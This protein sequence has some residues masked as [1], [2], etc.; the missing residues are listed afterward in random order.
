MVARHEPFPR[1]ASGKIRVEMPRTPIEVVPTPV[2]EPSAEHVS[3]W[4]GFWRHRRRPAT[5]LV[6]A[7]VVTLA[8]VALLVLMVN[9][10]QIVI[11]R[12]GLHLPVVAR[13]VL[14][15]SEETG[16]LLLAL[17]VL[18]VLFIVLRALGRRRGGG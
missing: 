5:L 13:F 15:F 7:V 6:K 10:A 8:V 9:L 16:E 11:E 3:K 14:D 17:L 12:H 18:P 2:D 1:T 4:R